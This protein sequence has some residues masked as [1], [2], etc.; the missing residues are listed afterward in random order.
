MNDVRFQSILWADPDGAGLNLF[1]GSFVPADASRPIYVNLLMIQ[2]MGPLGGFVH[3]LSVRT[4]AFISC[5]CCDILDVV[6]DDQE[7][8]VSTDSRVSLSLSYASA[9]DRHGCVH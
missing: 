4:V 7:S 9:F 2:S 1:L 3:Q 5:P 6:I 8:T